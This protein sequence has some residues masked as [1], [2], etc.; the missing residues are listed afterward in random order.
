MYKKMFTVLLNAIMWF[1][2]H[3][4]TVYCSASVTSERAYFYNQINTNGNTSYVKRSSYLVK[5]DAVKY[6]CEEINKDYVFASFKNIKGEITTGYINLKDIYLGTPTRKKILLDGE[7]T[8]NGGGVMISSVND[9]IVKFFIYLSYPDDNDPHTGSSW[10]YAKTNNYTSKSIYHDLE[11]CQLQFTLQNDVLSIIAIGEGNCSYSAKAWIENKYKRVK[12]NTT[13][14]EI[15][16]EML[17]F[18]YYLQ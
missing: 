3:V 7:Y 4:Q 9:S 5:N 2:A 11:D 18:H 12:S 8:I 17:I 6:K 15:E 10:G 16:N 13:L 14:K 1:Q